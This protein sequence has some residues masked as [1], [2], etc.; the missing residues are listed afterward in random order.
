MTPWDANIQQLESQYGVI[1][2][3][4]VTYLN[5]HN[6]FCLQWFRRN[7]FLETKGNNNSEMAYYLADTEEDDWK[8]G[9][10]HILERFSIA[11]TANDKRQAE[12]S[13]LPR[14]REIYLVSA[15]ILPVS[16]SYGTSTKNREIS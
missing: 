6:S 12:I 5:L 11:F 14:T 9:A 8:R 16:H 1:T 4:V 15:Y 3:N 10:L 2:R 7:N 13:R